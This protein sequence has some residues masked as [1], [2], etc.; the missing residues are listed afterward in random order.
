MSIKQTVCFVLLTLII[1]N[2][3][4]SE[5]IDKREEIIMFHREV[6]CEYFYYSSYTEVESFLVTSAPE[7]CAKKY[8]EYYISNMDYRDPRLWKFITA[9]LLEHDKELFEFVLNDKS[10][11]NSKFFYSLLKMTCEMEGF[12]V[13]SLRKYLNESNKAI[14][15]KSRN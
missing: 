6:G 8:Y 7:G 15:C 9:I 4:Y 10:G 3:L 13:D 14:D 2:S 1:Q 12:G 11:V 5:P